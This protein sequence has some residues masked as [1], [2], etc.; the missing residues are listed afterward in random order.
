MQPS[1]CQL[2][3]YREATIHEAILYDI[4]L[5][6]SRLPIQGYLGNDNTRDDFVCVVSSVTS[7]K[8]SAFLFFL[9]Q[10]STG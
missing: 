5:V 1:P 3:G 2:Q 6:G 9:V 4:R 10:F 7:F 8:K